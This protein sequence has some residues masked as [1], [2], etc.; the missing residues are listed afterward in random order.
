MQS[1][2]ACLYRGGP[3]ATQLR[4]PLPGCL[5][6]RF[7]RLPPSRSERS[8]STVSKPWRDDSKAAVMPASP[9]PITRHRG[10]TLTV[11]SCK[12]RLRVALFTAMR[13]RS[14]DLA[15]ARA[16]SDRFTQEH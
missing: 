15:V 9:P 13:T 12:G 3:L 14:Q 1:F 2:S 4:D 7:H 11:M 10:V 5:A 6:R 8:T 16:W